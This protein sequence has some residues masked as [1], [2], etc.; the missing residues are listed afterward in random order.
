MV[1]L[2]DQVVPQ[3]YKLDL[4]VDPT[5][6]NFKGQAQI[7][8]N[9]K[10][11]T[12]SIVLHGQDLI[13]E[14]AT[15]TLAGSDAGPVNVSWEET[16]DDGT[17]VFAGLRYVRPIG[18]GLY[19]AVI[20]YA[21]PFAGDLDGLYRVQYDGNWYAFTQFE[22]LAARKAFPGF[23][24]PRFKTPFSV[25]IHRRAG[26]VAIAN[27]ESI[28]VSKEV[29]QWV[30]EQFKQTQPSPTY[31]V[32]LAVGPFDI[33]EQDPIPP[34]E[35][36]KEPIRLRGIAA[37]GKAGALQY[38]LDA[39]REVLLYQEAH[40]KTPYVFGKMDFIAVPDFQA[41]AM[42]NTG[43]ITYRD[44]LLLIDPKTA[45][46]DQRRSSLSVIAHEI[47][48]QWFGNMVTMP[49]WDDLWLNES[50]A[51]WFEGRTLQAIRPEW[52][53]EL[54]D[55]RGHLSVM[56]RDA[57][58]SARQIR[59]P[60]MTAGDVRSAFDGITYTKG[61]AVLT[62]LEGY[63]GSEVFAAQIGEYLQALTHGHATADDLINSLSKLD[64]RAGEALASFIQQPGLPLLEMNFVCQ[65]GK[66]RVQFTQRRFE[67]VNAD[68]PA[69]ESG[70]R[71]PFCLRSLNDS[72][73]RFCDYATPGASFELGAC[74]EATVWVPD[75]GGK[76]YA[77]FHFNQS[78]RLT[79]LLEQIPS[80][81]I[82]ERLTVG[83]NTKALLDAGLA[84]PD[85]LVVSAEGLMA[86]GDRW[87]QSMAFGWSTDW[88]EDILSPEAQDVLTAWAAK[89]VGQ[90]QPKYTTTTF[91]PD[92][93]E[94]EALHHRAVLRFL[95][96]VAQDEKTIKALMA[97]GKA[98]LTGGVSPD[99]PIPES[100]ASTALMVFAKHDSEAAYPLL[101]EAI[102]SETDPSRRRTLIRGLT[103]VVGATSVQLRSEFES[104]GLRSNE[105]A[106]VLV[107]N[108]A[109]P[110]NSDAAWAWLQENA[111][112]V[113][114]KIPAWHFSWMPWMASRPCSVEQEEAVRELFEPLLKDVAGGER[115]LKK[116]Q[117]SMSQCR[118]LN[119]RVAKALEAALKRRASL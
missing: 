104:M 8:F 102:Q 113:K 1:R 53:P 21:A 83:S 82:A 84:T 12:R 19:T 111:A 16:H 18:P 57:Q 26:D 93:S 3:A 6:E 33:L 65:D 10:A 38:A 60:V 56:T 58:R 99:G 81:T 107:R 54:G 14:S 64:P 116:V 97:H 7:D 46:I 90:I 114:T 23:D 95:A 110:E 9:L 75:A 29:D 112:T 51:T 67:P 98:W 77:R 92:E 59:Q 25:T 31:L 45:T 32:A 4:Y 103:S 80:L 43:A 42:E 105:I 37:K 100:Y 17:A 47:A 40:L 24:E 20:K 34:S 118:E 108:G 86:A 27:E 69:S 106:G 70:W 15:L 30:A 61:S 39:H 55:R 62:M 44:F 76:A 91:S 41:G 88:L 49:W 5:L 48:H 119:G 22:P 36:R 73:A 109:K 66:Q 11:Q 87:S 74:N 72:S 13:V 94:A 71:T 28:S 35:W 52:R 96:N 68:L 85:D 78:E 50:F 115:S 101:K 89:R 79:A 63:L 2:S 117:E